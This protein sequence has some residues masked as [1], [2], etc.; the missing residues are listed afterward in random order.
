M[1]ELMLF[2]D[3][4]VNPQ[5]N[6]GYGAYLAV[7]EPGLALDSLRTRVKVKRFEHT[8]STKLELQTLLWALS[9]IQAVGRKVIVYTDSQNI[10]GLLERRGRLEKNDYHSKNNRRLKHYELYQAFYSMIDQ[11]DCKLI[12]VRGHQVADQKDDM[13]RLFTLVDRTSRKAL[14]GKGE[15]G[16]H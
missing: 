16:D 5:S 13:D 6:I 11:L 15:Q 4:S 1:D 14:R 3:G 12:K 9:D 10:L 2:V 7:S 8:S